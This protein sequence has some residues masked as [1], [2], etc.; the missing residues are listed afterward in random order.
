MSDLLKDEFL[1]FIV[2]EM[3]KGLPLSFYCFFSDKFIVS[4]LLGRELKRKGTPF[5]KAI[6]E[7]SI[8]SL[9]YLRINHQF[10]LQKGVETYYTVVLHMRLTL[11][12]LY[13]DPSRQLAC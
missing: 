4:F 6:F 11:L 5:A 13:L 2:P 8:L 10:L 7:K 9:F 3:R 12:V 1:H